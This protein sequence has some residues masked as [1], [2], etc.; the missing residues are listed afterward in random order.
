MILVAP[1]APITIAPNR[2]DWRRKSDDRETGLKKIS[3]VI[4][5]M[6]KKEGLADLPVYL[7]GI[8][9]GGD[10]ATMAAFTMPAK[11]KGAV[12]VNSYW[13]KYYVEDLL[14]KAKEAGLRIA[15]VHGKEHAFFPKAKFAIEQMTGA[16]VAGKLIEF[17]GDRKLPDN[18]ADLLQQAITFLATGK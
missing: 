9:I 7:M 15:L 5:E 17:D 2:F 4:E 16:G 12:Q 14:A 11:V 3:F 8:G 10:F 1:R 13:N 18:E 6:K